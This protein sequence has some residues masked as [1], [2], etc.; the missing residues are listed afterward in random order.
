MAFI[1]QINRFTKLCTFCDSLETKS[2]V[3]AYTFVYINVHVL[4]LR[5][6]VN[7]FY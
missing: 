5:V 3:S 7:F 2:N 4:V 6:N 1:Y